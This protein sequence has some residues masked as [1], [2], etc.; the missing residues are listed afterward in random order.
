M[1]TLRSRILGLNWNEIPF[2]FTIHREKQ[3]GDVLADK[4]LYQ[5][6]KVHSY[7]FMNERWKFSNALTYSSTPGHKHVNR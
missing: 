4:R 2:A 6:S 1:C 7:F 5:N 3:K